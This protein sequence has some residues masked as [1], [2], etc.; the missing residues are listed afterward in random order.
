MG[1]V[2][3]DTLTGDDG[4]NSIQGGA[5]ADTINGGGGNDTLNGAAGGDTINGGEGNDQ[6]FAGDGDDTINGDAGNDNLKGFADN[7]TINGGTGDDRLE[8]GD[9]NDTLTGGEGADRLFGGA[10]IDTALY[11]GSS[12][13]VTVNLA[14]RM[15]S[16]GDAQGDVLGGVENV[17]GSAHDDTLIGNGAA[18]R[19]DGAAGADTLTG[20]GGSDVFVF[21]AFAGDRI[22]DFADGSDMIEI[23]GGVFSDLTIAASGDDT[24]VS[25]NGGTLTLDDV[26]ASLITADDFSFV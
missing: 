10:G 11:T 25:W 26:S 23:S 1:S 21:S 4:V 18:N 9:G 20:G 22:T 24:T 8:G 17:T 6:V 5:G 15:G 3:D 12:A 14:T 19:L 2:H 7:D 16:G 13:A